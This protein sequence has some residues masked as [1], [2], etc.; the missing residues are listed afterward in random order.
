MDVKSFT[1]TVDSLIIMV[2]T[3]SKKSTLTNIKKHDINLN[4]RLKKEGNKMKSNIFL[5]QLHHHRRS[6]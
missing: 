4:I 6:L 5:N 3:L 1:I 2:Y